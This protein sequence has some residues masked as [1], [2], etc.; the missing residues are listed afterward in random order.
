MEETLLKGNGVFAVFMDLE[1]ILV[2]DKVDRKALW[3][4]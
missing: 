1:K 2:Y 4:I 3:E